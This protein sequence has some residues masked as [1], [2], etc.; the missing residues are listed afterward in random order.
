MVTEG[1]IQYDEDAFPYGV[2]TSILPHFRAAVAAHTRIKACSFRCLADCTDVLVSLELTD[3][4][5]REGRFSPEAL[6]VEQ[7]VT[8]E[9][10]LDSIAS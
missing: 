9:Q 5:P 3:G 7:S 6:L 2:R 4:S 8:A 1:K 10:I